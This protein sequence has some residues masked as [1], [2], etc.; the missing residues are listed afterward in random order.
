MPVGKKSGA[1]PKQ[2]PTPEYRAMVRESQRLANINDK[3][4]FGE[5]SEAESI[6]AKSENKITKENYKSPKAPKT[7]K[8]AK[9]N[10]YAKGGMVS[11][12]WGCA[13]KKGK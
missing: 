13:K 11:R 9:N 3:I 1:S 5:L 10:E 4:S 2:L 6:V 7:E 12:G 8:K